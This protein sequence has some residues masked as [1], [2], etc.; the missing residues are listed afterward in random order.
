MACLRMG[1][2]GS[3]LPKPRFAGVSATLTFRARYFE[4]FRRRSLLCGQQ[5]H[6]PWQQ[7]VWL[8]L[9]CQRCDVVS[10][11]GWVRDA[12]H[13]YERSGRSNQRGHS[14]SVCEGDGMVQEDQVEVAALEL[15]HRLYHRPRP[16]DEASGRSPGCSLRFK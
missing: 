5:S 16:S 10:T 13:R 14:L 1:G 3:K 9:N 11:T 4:P 12:D 6:D 8:I 2:W 15:V 7:R